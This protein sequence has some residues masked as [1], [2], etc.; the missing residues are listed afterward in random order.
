MQE[1]GSGLCKELKLLCSS[2]ALQRAKEQVLPGQLGPAS[3]PGSLG[4]VCAQ[5]GCARAWP[6][7]VCMA[8]HGQGMHLC[9]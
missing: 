2:Q 8:V 4:D 9:G 7:Y 1:S 6:G 3:I 5:Q